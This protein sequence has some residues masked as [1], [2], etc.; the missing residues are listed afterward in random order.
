M[1]PMVG[2]IM[3]M[4][5]FWWGTSEGRQEKQEEVEATI[6]KLS[7][8]HQQNEISRLKSEIENLKRN[9]II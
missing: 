1:I 4:A 5:A 6:I 9:Q 2:A 7:L 8:H 3:V